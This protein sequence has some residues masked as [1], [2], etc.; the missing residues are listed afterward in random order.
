MLKDLDSQSLGPA[1]GLEVFD[2]DLKR[3]SEGRCARLY[4]DLITHKLLV[5]R[6]QSLSAEDLLEVAAR[7]GRPMAYPF[8]RGLPGHP[9]VDEIVNEPEQEEKFSST[10]HADTTYLEHPPAITMLY[11]LEL[12]VTGG[13]SVVS[14][15][16]LAFETLSL[17]LQDLLKDVSVVNVSDLDRQMDRRQFLPRG[18]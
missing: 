4:D 5:F 3:P 16:R 13:E 10:W 18:R 11:A 12:P 6:D 9:R 17:Q 8:S 2:L 15:T 14:N 1:L 7:F